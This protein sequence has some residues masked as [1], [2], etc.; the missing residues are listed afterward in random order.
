MKI[1][2]GDFEDKYA[3]PC[4]DSG[5]ILLWGG[6][7]GI[8]FHQLEKGEEVHVVFEKFFGEAVMHI[9]SLQIYISRLDLILKLQIHVNNIWTYPCSSP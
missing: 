2:Y 5:T 4:K 7:T 1:I 3:Y 6:C 9:S 8:S